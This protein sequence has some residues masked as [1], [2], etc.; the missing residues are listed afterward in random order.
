MRW[1]Q[2]VR[3]LF[4]T[5]NQNRRPQR[6]RN[7]RVVPRLL[8]AVVVGLAALAATALTP[9]QSQAWHRSNFGYSYYVYSSY[10]SPGYYG[11][12][13][14]SSYHSPDYGGYSAYSSSPSYY[15]PGYGSY[16]AYYGPGYYGYGGY[17][18]YYGPGY[19]GYCFPGGYYRYR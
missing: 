11:Y 18:A 13:R 1:V 17:S 16:S 7:N 9:A 3:K 14:Y 10:Y 12:G 8:P 2:T 6:D 5:Q 4:G 15:G 19:G